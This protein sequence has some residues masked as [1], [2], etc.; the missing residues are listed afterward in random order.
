MTE[1]LTTIEEEIRCVECG[2]TLLLAPREEDPNAS[3]CAE[4]ECGFHSSDE[5]YCRDAVSGHTHFHKRCFEA[6]KKLDFEG[7]KK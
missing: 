2:E 5:I 7:L 4:C 3:C 1:V 6:L